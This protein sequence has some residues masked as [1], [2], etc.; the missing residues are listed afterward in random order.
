MSNHH[1]LNWNQN[2]GVYSKDFSASI[3][4]KTQLFFTLGEKVSSKEQFDLIFPLGKI[5]IFPSNVAPI[6][7]C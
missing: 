6:E 7:N 3:I 1:W 2:E 5:V 4:L